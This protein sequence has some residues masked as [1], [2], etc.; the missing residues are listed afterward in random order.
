MDIR[1]I[2]QI[3]HETNREY[4]FLVGDF[5]AEPWGVA[6]QWQQ[7]SAINGVQFH[8][9]NPNASPGQSHENWLRE[10]QGEGWVYGLVKDPDA[11]IHPCCVSYEDLPLE[12]RVKD[13]LFIGVVRALIPLLVD[14]SPRQ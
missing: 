7:D 8:I 6:P 11:K 4:C 10:K 12:Q 14:L 3:A 5:T 13:S 1:D 2:A 9:D